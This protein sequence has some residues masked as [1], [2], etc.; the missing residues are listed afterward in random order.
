MDSRANNAGESNPGHGGGIYSSLGDLE[1]LEV[2]VARNRA[3]ITANGGGIF[4]DGGNLTIDRSAL[5]DNAAGNSVSNSA[6]SGGDGGGLFSQ[7]GNVVLRN[8]TVSGNHAGD[9]FDS[10]FTA[11]YGGDGGGVFV[12]DG[13]LAFMGSTVAHNSAG[14]GTFVPGSFGGGS[15]GFGLG[16]GVLVLRSDLT[17]TNSIVADNVSGAAPDIADIGLDSLTVSYS[18]IGDSTGST[19]DVADGPGIL[20]DLDPMLGFLSDNGGPTLT[21]PISLGSPAVDAGDPAAAHPEFDQRGAPFARVQDGDGDNALRADMGAFE[22]PPVAAPATLVVDRLLDEDDGDYSVGDL[23]L[24]EAVELANFLPGADTISFAPIIGGDVTVALSGSLRVTDS[25]TLTGPGASVLT[26]DA[27]RRARLFTIDDGDSMSHSAVTIS[28]LSLVDGLSDE[29]GGAVLNYENLTLRDVVVRDSEARSGGGGVYSEGPLEIYRSEVRNN[30][31]RGGGGVYQ[32]GAA[33]R[34]TESTVSQ[35]SSLR[36]LLFIVPGAPNHGGGIFA[37]DAS[38]VILRSTI[39]G[40]YATGNGGGLALTGAATSLQIE[41]STFSG[42]E[43]DA[44]GG[45]LHVANGPASVL[46]ST[47]AMNRA[48]ADA[49]GGGMG[50]GVAV[51]NVA[52]LTIEHT[53]VGPNFRGATGDD[54][55]VMAGGGVV[56]PRFNLISDAATAGGIT[57]VNGNLVGAPSFLGPLADNGGLTRTHLPTEFSF[58]IDTGNASF[59]PP[60]QYDQRGAPFT[61]VSGGRI[62]I[63]AVEVQPPITLPSLP[64]DYNLDG[65]VDAADYSVW[66]DAL[67]QSVANAYDGAD[68]DGDLMIDQDDYAVWRANYGRTAAPAPEVFVDFSFNPSQ[69]VIRGTDDPERYTLSS[70][71]E[72]VTLRYQRVGSAEFVQSYNATQLAFTSGGVLVEARGGNDV[73]DASG[74]VG[75]F[76]AV[77]GGQGDDLLLGSPQGDG[78]FGLAGRDLL[79]GGPGDDSLIGDFASA[80]HP[81]SE[82]LLISGAVVAPVDLAALEAVL[83][84]G[85]G[86]GD[87]AARVAA[88][89]QTLVANVNVVDDQAVDTV[90]GEGGDDLYYATVGTPS[91]NDVLPDLVSPPEVV[92]VTHPPIPASLLASEALGL[93]ATG[94]DSSIDTARIAI[95]PELWL[96]AATR[97]AVRLE[98]TLT[99]GQ[100]DGSVV[101]LQTLRIPLASATL[102][103]ASGGPDRLAVIDVNVTTQEILA[104]SRVNACTTLIGPAGLAGM[105]ETFTTCVVLGLVQLS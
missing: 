7:N 88:V 98:L 9:G 96:N 33:L 97:S 73:V 30:S 71:G 92:E 18:L 47:I 29:G 26:L 36:D 27:E 37:E 66:R 48:D 95:P 28:G 60:P 56:N 5:H 90:L 81:P 16:G 2:T 1:L 84:T 72:T 82:D 75:R 31:G 52:Q 105:P 32:R 80:V 62:D 50:G 10:L 103:S 11:S 79:V 83:A 100:P 85:A 74:L 69:L 12:V 22:R 20:L 14:A 101:H 54:L 64:G 35:N 4:H 49:A 45:G 19:L 17:V 99:E 91:N 70:M 68:G 34:F 55:F 40:N 94:N 57:S 46:H 93:V 44:S 104:G 3:G 76:A 59:A 67:G 51:G 23:S 6:P 58:A 24:R 41:S 42:N 63:G 102:V 78:L 43:A 15:G 61:R 89:K 21:V 38:T 77:D 8:S 87:H 13:S 86:P 25:L 53:I 39:D 65:V